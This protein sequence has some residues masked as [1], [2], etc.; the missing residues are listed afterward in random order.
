MNDMKIGD[1]VIC[2]PVKIVDI[3]HTGKKTENKEQAGE[4]VYI[5]PLRRYVTVAFPFRGGILRESFPPGECI[6]VPRNRR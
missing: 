4:I 5:H 1:K 3:D 6:P 2:R